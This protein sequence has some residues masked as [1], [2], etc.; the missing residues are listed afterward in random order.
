M[1]ATG[2]PGRRSGRLL[3]R[4]VLRRRARLLRQAGVVALLLPGVPEEGQAG[5][6]GGDG[7]GQDHRQ[8][9]GGEHQEVQE[10]QL[11]LQVTDP[12]R[13]VESIRR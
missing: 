3:S 7:G 13:R 1:R 12:F 4:P 11:F 2:S 6:R 9:G 5:R 10:R 8:G